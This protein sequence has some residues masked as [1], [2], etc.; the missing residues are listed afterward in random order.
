M[1][2]ERLLA[3]DRDFNFLNASNVLLSG[4]KPRALL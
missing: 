2:E 4:F 1:G 3:L